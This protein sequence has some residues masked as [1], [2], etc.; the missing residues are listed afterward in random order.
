M[1]KLMFLGTGAAVAAAAASAALFGAGVAG[2]A[3]DVVGQTYADAVSAIEEEGSSAVVAV[4]VGS[5]LAQDDCIVTNATDAPFVRDMDF[6]GEFGHA[7]SEVMLSLNCDGGYATAT[8]PG[9]S[10]ASPAGRLAKAAADEA[11]AAEEQELLQAEE[12]ASKG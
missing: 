9:A 4:R 7:D 1:K 10:L 12:D 8:N 3:P 11:A 2:A 5:K 6:A